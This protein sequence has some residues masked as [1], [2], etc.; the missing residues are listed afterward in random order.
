TP[1]QVLVI[2]ETITRS[3]SNISASSNKV[4]TPP[5]SKETSLVLDET[6]KGTGQLVI[7]ESRP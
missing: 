2:T 5:I 3:D 6:S 7:E 4:I 1:T